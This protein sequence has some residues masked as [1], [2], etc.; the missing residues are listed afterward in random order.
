MRVGSIV[1]GSAWFVAAYFGMGIFVEGEVGRY[2]TGI[3]ATFGFLL[4]EQRL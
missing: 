3:L 1:V 4:V 2:V